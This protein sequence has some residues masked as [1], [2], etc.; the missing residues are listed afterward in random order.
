[1]S[2]PRPSGE[3]PNPATRRRSARGLV[4]RV[5]GPERLRAIL[6]RF[7][8]V[9]VEDPMV[10]FFFAG[11]DLPSIIEG[12]YRFLLRAF[13]A[14]EHFDGRNPGIAHRDLAPI[15]R[16]HFDRRLRVLDGV[17]EAE[18]LDAED[19]AAWLRV[20]EGFRKM[21]QAPGDCHGPQRA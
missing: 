21:I 19:R 16:G 12:Q 14:A 17:L 8:A 18:G 9:L 20:E 11:R 2:A 13:G 6:E 10:G 3:Q 15:L 1:M 7:Y 5:G 4:D